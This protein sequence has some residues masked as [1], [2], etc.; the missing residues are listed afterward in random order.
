MEQEVN[1]GSAMSSEIYDPKKTANG[2]L[3]TNVLFVGKCIK[4]SSR[5]LVVEK[6]YRAVQHKKM[7]SREEKKKNERVNGIDLECCCRKI[8]S[9]Y[10][11]IL[12]A[13]YVHVPMQINSSGE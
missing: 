13:L 7:S 2:K 12:G 4:V 8:R 3:F 11:Y 10:L 6:A 1:S 9:A 5:K